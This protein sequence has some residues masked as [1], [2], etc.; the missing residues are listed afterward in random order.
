MAGA[1]LMAA[2]LPV[3]VAQAQLL[4]GAKPLA[5]E[6]LPL[7]GEILPLA[8]GRVLAADMIAR[9]SQPPFAAAAMDGYAIRWADL[10]GPWRIV[11]EAAAGRGWTGIIAPGQAARIFTGAPI[12][13]GA[14]TIIIQEDVLRDD[15]IISLPSGGPDAIGAHIRKLGQDFCSGDTIARAGNLLTARRMGLLAA[16]GHADAP[17]IRRPVVTLIATGDELVP[18]GV[19]PGPGQIV[20]ANGIMLAALFQSAGADVRDLGIVPD[21]RAALAAALGTAGGDVIATI[22]GASVGDHDLV[23]PVLR[24]LGADI[25]FWK[26]ALRPGKPMLAGRL[27]A[28]R[29]VGLPGNPVSAYVC[30]LLFVVP[31]LQRLGGRAEVTPTQ[32]LPLATPLPA[33]G[34][35]RDHLRGRLVDGAALA[36]SAQ[37]SAL[38]ERLAAADLLIIRSPNAP[39]AAIGEHVDCIMLDMFQTVS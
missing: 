1:G 12:P 31:L 3:D 36:F 14:D 4:A 19:R 28:A 35:R 26:I 11:G 15:D 24:A 39:A 8:T 10:P 25:D 34:G 23:M 32:R 18:P 27:G 17:V 16:A 20:S 33:N 29:V 6:I 7:G 2:L 37:D 9:L 21:D 38:L 22:G 30:A 13:A 5:A